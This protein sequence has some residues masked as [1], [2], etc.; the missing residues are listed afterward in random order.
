MPTP[1]PTLDWPALKTP[2]ALAGITAAVAQGERL[3]AAL[4]TLAAG[5]VVPEHTHDN[6]EFGQ[7]LRGSLEL[8]WADQVKVLVAGDAFILP[9][10]VPHGARALDEECELLECYAPPRNPVPTGPT[11]GPR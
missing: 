6:E 10:G 9:A 2:A 1:D 8:R 5:A 7:V 11:G 3:S 4:F